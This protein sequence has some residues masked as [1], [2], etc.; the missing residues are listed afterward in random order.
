MSLTR[1]KTEIESVAGATFRALRDMDAGCPGG[2]C[3]YVSCSPYAGK[4]YKEEAAITWGVT[5]WLSRHWLIE[6]EQ[7]DYKHAPFLVTFVPFVAK[8]LCFG[9]RPGSAAIFNRRQT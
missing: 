1:D 3:N 2:L 5:E 8:S 6:Q 9:D 4:K 7:H